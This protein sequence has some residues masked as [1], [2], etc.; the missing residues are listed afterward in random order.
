MEDIVRMGKTSSQDVVNNCKT[1]EVS[2]CGNVESSVG[3]PCQNYCKQHVF[4]D[5]WPVIEHPIA[6]NLQAP[7]MSASNSSG[8]LEHPSLH[9]TEICSHRNIELDV[10]PVSWRDA[11]CDDVESKEI[12][13]SVSSKHTL[14]SSI[15]GLQ[16]DFNSN[17]RTTLSPDLCSSYEHHKDVSSAASVFHRLTLGADC[18]HLS[19]GTYNSGSNSASVVLTSNHLFKNGMEVK[20]AAVDN[21]SAHS[22]DYGD[23][24]LAFDVSRGEA[25]D[26]NIDVLSS[27]KQ[28]LV[29]HIVPEETLEHDHNMTASVSDPN[30]LKSHLVNT[31][32]PLKQIGLQSRNH[33]TFPREWCAASNSMPGDVLALLRSQSQPARHSNAL[34]SISYPAIFMSKVMASGAFPLPM[35]SV[36]PQEPTVQSSTHFLELLDR[37]GYLSLPSQQSFPGNTTYKQSPVDMKYNLPQNRN[38]FLTNRLP[39]R[40]TARDA[41]GYGFGPSVYNSRSFLSNPSPSHMIPSSNFNETLSSSY[42][43]GLDL[44]STNQ[45]GSF[46]PWDYGSESR[47]SFVPERAQ[48]NNFLGQANQASLSQYAS[49][50]YSNLNHSQPRILEELQ[51]PGGVQDLSSKQLHQFWQ[52]NN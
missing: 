11:A 43:G 46:S 28:W 48:Y 35:R 45:H 30:F 39:P 15:T 9:V 19:F 14:L 31:S 49:P 32:L 26:K 24:Q 27:P 41:F 37:K 22:V 10:A 3:L 34:P 51:H 17:L 50:G 33:F 38:E 36:H 21:S 6:R 47:S 18:S 20:S 23:K 12:E 52:H 44:S 2:A 42:N 1:S 8:P 4:N 5:E 25:G 40:A 29:K 13:S 16:S 7:N